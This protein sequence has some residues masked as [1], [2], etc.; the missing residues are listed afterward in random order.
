MKLF[1]AII[2]LL[3]LVIM[4]ALKTLESEGSTSSAMSAS[5]GTLKSE[6]STSSAERWGHL[7]GKKGSEAQEYIKKER[8]DLQNVVIVS[9]NMPV[10]MDFSKDRVRVF[11]DDSGNVVRTPIVG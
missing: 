7:V 8:P 5:E 10:T 4:S 6:G 2:L 3:L 1:C 11:V 9:S